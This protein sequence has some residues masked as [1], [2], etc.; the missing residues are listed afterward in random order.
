MSELEIAE[1][2]TARYAEAE[3]LAVA[4]TP[5]PIEGTWRAAR[6]KHASADAPLRLV[7]G[8]DPLE[9]EE[10]VSSGEY[11]GTPI[12][13]FS[14]EWQAEAEANLRYI[15]YFNPAR[16]LADIAAKRERLARYVTA[17]AKLDEVLANRGKYGSGDE[18]AALGRFAAMSVCVRLDAMTYAAHVDFDDEW[19]IDG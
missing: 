10:W 18:G 14:A 4:T 12:I 1:F 13:A 2:L 9:G 6:D 8:A 11:F 7:Q 5:V 3:A 17:K 19:R 15:A 16:A